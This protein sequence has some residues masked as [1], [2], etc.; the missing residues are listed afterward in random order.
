MNAPMVFLFDGHPVRVVIDDAG[1]LAWVS[2]DVCDVL[3]YANPTDALKQHCKG[4]AKYYPLKTPGGIQHFRIVDEPDLYRLIIGSHLSAA[5]RFERWV[6]EEVLPSIRKTGSYS[7]PQPN[8]T[9]PSLPSVAVLDLD[10]PLVLVTL[11]Q[12]F[13]AKIQELTAVVQAQTIQLEI[14]EPKVAAYQAFI[15]SNFEV[16]LTDAAKLLRLRPRAE[17]IA[18]LIRDGY[19]IK[20]RRKGHLFPYE[21]HLRS[22]I[23][24]VLTCSNPHGERV[25][26]QTVVTAKGLDFF[27]QRYN[28]GPRE[29]LALPTQQ[30]TPGTTPA[31]EDHRLN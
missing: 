14:Q 7:V 3:G 31:P 17:F 11:N 18:W 19:I 12:R 8:A 22:G 25:W 10:N 24:R 6:F 1:A 9:P 28:V 27:R 2:K 29:Q 23:F 26:T 20:P 30:T 13:T 4:V 15:D 21:E 16:C 5:Q